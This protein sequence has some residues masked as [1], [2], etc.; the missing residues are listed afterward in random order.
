M[1]RVDLSEILKTKKPKLYHR[2][3]RFFVRWIERL[4]C[5]ERV[6]EVLELFGDKSGVPFIT[7]TLN[8]LKIKRSSKGLEKLDKKRRYLFASNHPLGG[9]DGFSL[10]EQIEGYFGDVKLVVN[11]ILMNLTPVSGVFIPINKHGRQS[12]EYAKGLQQGLESNTPIVYFP[13][14]LC[15]RLIKGKIT[16]PVWKKSFIQKA[17]DSKR[18][19]VPTFIDD[20]NSRTFYCI[21]KARKQ[22]GIKVNIEMLLLPRELFKKEGK[23]NIIIYYGTPITHERLITDEK[24]TQEWVEYIRN[25]CYNLNPK[26]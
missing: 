9:L 23:G 17:I 21:A 13:S 5:Q 6:N 11:D 2:I 8:H 19:V 10:A 7:E 24:S 25:E 12:V 20:R 14:G 1:I 22:L 15:S 26:R 3:P 4:I 16:D 18:D